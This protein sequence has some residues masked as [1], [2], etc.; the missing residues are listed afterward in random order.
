MKK[1]ELIE[2]MAAKEGMSKKYAETAVDAMLKAITDALRRGEAVIL[3]GFG[4]FSVMERAEHLPRN[5]H[6]GETFMA[7]AR[8]YP[9]F[10]PSNA[11]K[12]VVAGNSTIKAVSNNHKG[13]V[14]SPA[15][16]S[17][18]NNTLKDVRSMEE[19]SNA[20]RK[21]VTHEQV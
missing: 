13:V 11:L 14:A 10:K 20:G 6:T 19:Q 18:G 1:G 3:P 2:Q 21:D 7:P 16:K 15:Q 12:N 4:T 5:T 8:R 9:T 17:V